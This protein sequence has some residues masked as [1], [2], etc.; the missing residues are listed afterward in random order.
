MLV[1]ISAN[2][3]GLGVRAGILAQTLMQRTKTQI[4]EKASN[5]ALNPA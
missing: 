4:Y 3:L 2:G 1:K 5:E